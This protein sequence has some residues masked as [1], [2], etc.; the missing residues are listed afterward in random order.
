MKKIAGPDIRFIDPAPAVAKQL[1]RVMSEEGLTES[2]SECLSGGIN[3]SD[4]SENG[5]KSVPSVELLSSGDCAP[6][7]H[8]FD[9]IY[10]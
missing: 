4:L 7:H 9:L 5:K 2:C 3:E 8:L 1:L 10:R 6:L